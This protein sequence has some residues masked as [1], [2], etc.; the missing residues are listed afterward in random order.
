[1]TN[2][3]VS[4]PPLD[5][6]L[7]QYRVLLDRLD[8]RMPVDERASRLVDAA[9][10]VCARPVFDTFLS[11]PRL[12]FEPFG[13]QLQAAETVLR[14]LHGRAILADEVG[15]GKTIE[16]GLVLSELRLRGL[17]A[18]VLVLCPVGLVEQWQEELDRKFALPSATLGSG[19]AG[20]GGAGPDT[21]PGEPPILL[22]SLSSARRAPLRDTL[23]AVRWD[24]VVLDEAHRVKNPS[25]ASA[26]LVRDLRARHLLLL[27]ATPVENRLSDLFNLTN[28]V[29]PGVL[30]TAREFRARHG[31]GVDGPRNGAALRA[32]MADVVIRHRRSEVELMLPRRLA[33]TLSVRPSP[34]EGRVYE[35]V[36]ERVRRQGR[37]VPSAGTMAWSVLRMAGSSPAALRSSLATLGWTDL[38]A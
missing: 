28:L 20:L 29:A 38:E 2:A 12:R 25:T 16:A 30:G 35:D 14:R 32:R 9:L 6:G 18:R 1:M 31:G 19:A 24:L 13:Y 36:A 37:E 7:D 17:A 15:L 21:A 3:A 8:G 34:A 11:L 5:I 22:A 26:R 33:E 4:A 23:A 10:D 27:T